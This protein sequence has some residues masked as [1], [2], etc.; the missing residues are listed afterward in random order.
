M[1][2]EPVKTAPASDRASAY[3]R[4]SVRGAGGLS[5]ST[6]INRPVALSTVD[7]R[8][9]PRVET[10]YTELDRVLGGGIVQDLLYWSAV[11]PE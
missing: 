1:V 7:L 2:E 9:E 3:G 10:G 4:K 11:I 5:Q 8:E 6:G